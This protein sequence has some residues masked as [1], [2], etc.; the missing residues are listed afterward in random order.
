MK[1]QIYLI[2]I[3]ILV[4]SFN[5]FNSSYINSIKTQQEYKKRK[6]FEKQKLKFKSNKIKINTIKDTKKIKR[7]LDDDEDD[8]E[9]LTDN[10]YTR[11]DNGHTP[12]DISDCTKHETSESSC[13]LFTYGQDTGCVL[14]G[15]KYLGSK[16]VGDMVVDCE[17]ETI[18]IYYYL[19]TMMIIF[20]LF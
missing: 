13:C 6:K 10:V 9:E 20:V 11:C 16:T 15:F 19:L 7:K 4:I 5:T 14:I 1:E 8:D 17:S 2:S 18:G 3:F 12:D